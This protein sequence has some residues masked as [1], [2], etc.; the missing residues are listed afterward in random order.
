[1][2]PF[3][4]PLVAAAAAFSLAA[5]GPQEPTPSAPAPVEDSRTPAQ[6]EAE[7]TPYQLDGFFAQAAADFRVPAD[8]LKAV[9]YTETRWEMVKGEQEFEGMPAAYGLMGL[10]G[11][12]VAEG[13]RL[14]GVSE[15]AVRTQ[16]EANIRAYAALLSATA[17][18]LKLDRSEVGAWAPAVA[19]LSGITS[20]DAQ[21]EY[22]HNE[23]YNVMRLGA[24]AQTPAGDLAVSLMPTQVRAQFDSPR[25]HALATGPDYAASIWRPSP[26][27]NARPTGTQGDVQI[28]VIHTCEGSYSS[29]WSWLTNSASGVS[30]HYVVNESGSEISQLVRESDRGWHVGATYDC[31]LNGGVMCGLQG[32]SV[33]HFSVGIEHGGFASQTSFPAGQIDASARLT[34]DITQGQAI[35]RDSYH[36]V[37]HG[38][39]QPA[40]RTDP[41]PNWPWST[42]ISK[43]QSYCGA[44]TGIVVD[45]NNAN[46]DSSKGYI[47]VSANWVSSTNVA[48]YYGSGYFAAPTAAV[49][50]PATFWFYLP[51]AGTKTIEAWWTSATDRSTTAPFIIWDANG[52]KLATVNKNQQ[53]GGGAWNALGTWS[54]PAGWNKVQLSRWTTSGYQVIADAIRVR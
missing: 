39:L 4:K 2:H 53:T 26:N 52:T 13:A 24:V 42:Y 31:N 48:G 16:P 20:A 41:G 5:C 3:R 34:C 6:R 32:V 51:A 47:E 8:L 21:A 9:S 44:S 12:N 45:S 19:K 18:E 11:A 33:N 29:C 43:V 38:R 14:A 27:Y 23:V 1:M 25:V 22:I 10:R 17:D 49:S 46:N 30:A 54:F 40:S 50:D 15:E 28:V 35:V 36:I 7:R 37:A